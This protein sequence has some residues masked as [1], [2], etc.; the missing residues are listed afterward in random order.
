MTE[1]WGELGERID[2]LVEEALKEEEG[3]IREMIASF[4]LMQR[5]RY[6]YLSGFHEATQTEIPRT[7]VLEVINF[8]SLIE[9]NWREINRRSPG[10]PSETESMPDEDFTIAVNATILLRAGRAKSERAA[11]L[12]AI[13][14]APRA[15]L[16]NPTMTSR[17]ANYRR[18]RKAMR[19]YAV[20]IRH[21]LG[22]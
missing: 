16:P 12:A 13:D 11:I 1:G 19:R 2:Q 10:R 22:E 6:D 20:D 3:W 17:E 9:R 15:W 4:L 7:D 21:H 5:R 14:E 18:I 8:V